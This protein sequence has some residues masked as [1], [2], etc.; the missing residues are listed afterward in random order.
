MKMQVR[1]K[2]RT[3]RLY[4][5][6]ALSVVVLVLSLFVLAFAGKALAMSGGAEWNT[7]AFMN[8][9]AVAK[10]MRFT[11][12]VVSR[13]TRA[14]GQHSLAVATANG[15]LT[16]RDEYARFGQEYNEAK[17]IKVGSPVQGTY[18]TIDNIN[19]LTWIRYME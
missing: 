15:E 9:M 18:K 2:F 1:Y 13:A 7:E 10:E 14:S 5:K 12:R 19:Y 6:K 3:G 4:M 17:G 16:F 8:E 11:G